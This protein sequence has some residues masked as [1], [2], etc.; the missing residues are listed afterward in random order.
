MLSRPQTLSINVVASN[1]GS[2]QLWVWQYYILV[3][4]RLVWVRLRG[5][6][7]RQLVEI[8]VLV[9][10]LQIVT[11]CARMRTR[12]MVLYQFLFLFP[13]QFKVKESKI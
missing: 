12:K 6:V 8:N 3:R 1:G 5:E 13:L 7:V 10:S 9:F 4:W 2:L 11:L